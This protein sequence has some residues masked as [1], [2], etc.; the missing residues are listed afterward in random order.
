MIRAIERR[1][2]PAVVALYAEL[3]GVDVDRPNPGYHYFFDRLFLSDPELTNPELPSYVYEDAQRG[4]VGVIGSH[5]RR[6]LLEEK[7]LLLACPGPLIVHPDFRSAGVGATLLRR[8]VA[9]TQALTFDDRAVDAVRMM[10]RLMGGTTDGLASIEWTRVLDVA[11][12]VTKRVMRRASMRGTPP[13]GALVAS[14]SKPFSRAGELSP[15]GES[16]ELDHGSLVELL[17]SLRRQYPLRPDYTPG[18]LDSLYDLMA[19][20]V[21]GTTVTRRLVRGTNGRPIGAY[22]MIVAPRGSANVVNLVVSYQHASTVMEHLFRD[23]SLAGAVDVAGRCDP[24]IHPVLSK[25][26]CRL[27]QGDWVSFWS[28]DEELDGLARSGRALLPRMEGEW[29]MRPD[30]KG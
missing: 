29:W 23:A 3:D 4:V 6:F 26:G 12:H 20:T 27:R 14:L 28:A 16:E 13:G 22:V 30:P 9:G 8:F 24:T 2:L 11:G 21:L 7:P 15:S 25:L 10:W 19:R 17:T 1:D 18:Y 5:P